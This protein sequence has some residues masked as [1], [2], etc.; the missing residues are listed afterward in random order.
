VAKNLADCQKRPFCSL[1]GLEKPLFKKRYFP[2][3]GFL[4]WQ[5]REFP[6]VPKELK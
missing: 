1:R 6:A 3:G 5:G 4:A 2:K